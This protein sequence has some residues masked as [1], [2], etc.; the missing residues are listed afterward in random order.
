MSTKCR[1]RPKPRRSR[2]KPRL[3]VADSRV[4]L[5]TAMLRTDDAASVLGLRGDQ[6]KTFLAI[7]APEM[8]RWL[9]LPEGLDPRQWGGLPR[10]I[11]AGILAN[12]VE[13]SITPAGLTREQVAKALQTI[14]HEVMGSPCEPEPTDALP[15]SADKVGVM[16]ARAEAGLPLFH[17]QDRGSCPGAAAA[18]LV[19]LFGA[20]IEEDASE[21]DPWDPGE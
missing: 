21:G 2:S 19:A 14:C 9:T 5:D 6:R 12:R 3:P 20:R 11:G 8:D 16:T 4:L 15:G 7:I 13:A 18:R 10:A 1:V 17:P